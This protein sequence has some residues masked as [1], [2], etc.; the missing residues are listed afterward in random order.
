[1]NDHD[2]GLSD[3]LSSD[4][5]DVGP[6]WSDERFVVMA[7]AFNQSTVGAE[8]WERRHRPLAYVLHVALD[9]LDD[10]LR[11]IGWRTLSADQ[12]R[13]MV[14]EQLPCRWRRFRCDRKGLPYPEFGLDLAQALADARLASGSRIDPGRT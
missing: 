4:G 7:V 8:L 12:A 3:L 2:A 6:D 11:S 13:R 5:F 9:R 14:F 1:M 10:M